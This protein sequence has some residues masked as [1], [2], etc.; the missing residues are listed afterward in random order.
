MASNFQRAQEHALTQPDPWEPTEATCDMVQVF[1]EN[2]TMCHQSRNSADEYEE[3]E[4]CRLCGEVDSHSPECP[5]PAL[6]SWLE[7]DAR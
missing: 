6:L 3:F 7:G 2:T 1:I 5:L 4:E